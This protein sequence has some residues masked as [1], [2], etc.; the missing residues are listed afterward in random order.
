MMFLFIYLFIYYFLPYYLFSIPSSF[1]HLL[2][3]SSFSG[4]AHARASG[5]IQRKKIVIS[6]WSLLGDCDNI[7]EQKFY[8][9]VLGYNASPVVWLFMFPLMRLSSESQLKL[10][11]YT[12]QICSCSCLG[13]TCTL[14]C[15]PVCSIYG[16]MRYTTK[17]SSTKIPAIIGC[18]CCL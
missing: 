17:N 14:Y 9:R 10:C 16:K 12:I 13:D 18:C 6:A 7:G 11:G 4:T 1:Y 8:T 3:H 15:F 5:S 2:F